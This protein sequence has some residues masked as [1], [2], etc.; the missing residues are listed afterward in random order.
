MLKQAHMAE[1]RERILSAARRLIAH[2]GVGGMTL[3]DLA[4][5]AM[6]SVPTVYNLIGGKAQL[7]EALMADT[8]ARLAARLADAPAGGV[9]E[10]AMALC[11]AGV[12]E[13]LAEPKYFRELVHAFLVTPETHELRREVDSRN[14]AMM[15]S[16]LTAGRASGELHEWIDPER[17]AKLLWTTYVATMLRW[18][19]GELTD[20]A[21]PDTV[22]YGLS[23]ILLGPA[24]GPTARK[25]ERLARDAQKGAGS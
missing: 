8:F 16:I 23:L 19:A 20:A 6:V 1:N 17:V 3:R 7:L 18:A 4:A 25:L 13:M 2:R 9:V 12:Q 22:V 24:R 21:L 14:V 5:E 10:R 11:T 15:S